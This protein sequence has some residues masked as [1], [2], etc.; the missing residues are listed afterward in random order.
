MSLQRH[1]AEVLAAQQGGDGVVDRERMAD[2]QLR[3]Q[4]ARDSEL[5]ALTQLNNQSSEHRVRHAHPYDVYIG[6]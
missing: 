6:I 2:L 1:A 5:D 4:R 3:L